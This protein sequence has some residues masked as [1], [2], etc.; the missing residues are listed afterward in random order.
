MAVKK[1]ANKYGKYVVPAPIM[2]IPHDGYPWNMVY[3]HKGETQAPATLAFAYITEPFE[4]G[5]PH[6]H[7]AHQIMCF[8]GSNLKDISEFD[9]TVEIAL[10]D[11]LEIQTITS[12]SIVS[13]PPMMMHCPLRFTRIGKPLL[14]IEIV[15][16]NAYGRVVDPSQKIDVYTKLL[17]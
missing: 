11:E 7:D 2:I 8:V 13:I 5:P 14:F 15:L 16:Q 17:K 6:K 4:E 1:V 3:A 10:G 9:A 12:P